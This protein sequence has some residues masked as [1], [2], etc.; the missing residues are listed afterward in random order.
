MKMADDGPAETHCHVF[1]LC[2]WRINLTEDIALFKSREH[3]VSL[4][5]A[6]GFGYISHIALI[7]HLNK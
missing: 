1:K 5:L 4:E 6:F 3:F 7:C 2:V